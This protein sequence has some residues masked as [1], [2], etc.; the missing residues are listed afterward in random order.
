MLLVFCTIVLSLSLVFSLAQFSLTHAQ[1]EDIPNLVLGGAPVSAPAGTVSCFDYYSFG[2]VQAKLTSPVAS[3]VSGAT[4]TFTGVLENANPY[5]IVDGALYVKVFKSRGSTNDGNGPDVVDQFFV[6]DGITIPAE[7]SVP[8]TFQWRVPSYAQNG[9]YKLATFFTTSHKFN[10]LGLSFTD[11]VVGNTVAFSVL[12]EQTSGVSFYKAKATVD[13]KAY[14]FAAVPPRVGSDSATVQAIVRNTGATS[15]RVTISWK[16][17]Q[18]DAQTEENLVEESATTITVPAKSSAPVSITVTDTRYPVYLVVGELSWRDTHS[19]IGVRFVRTDINRPR[20]NF[21]SVMAFPL[22]ENEGNTL[23]SCLHNSAE[24]TVPNGTLSLTLS[25]K[26]GRVIHEYSYQ[27][28]IT[29][30]MMGVAEKFVP[31]KTYDYFTLDATLSQGD[32]LVDSAHLVYDCA[33]IDP[34]VCAPQ[35]SKWLYYAGGGALV[36]LA[37]YAFLRRR[38]AHVASAP[39]AP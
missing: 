36:L 3:T 6:Q 7:S 33:K 11:D 1:E 4:M 38:R 14:H 39:I 30:A 19:V 37:L 29:G 13:G 34:S 10:L 25:D 8:L 15:E 28:D 31:K 20:I 9:D 35:S 17:Y 24:A 22:K 27:G 12:G 26:R 16:V 32:Q 2:S 18:W 5:P 21:P 23:F